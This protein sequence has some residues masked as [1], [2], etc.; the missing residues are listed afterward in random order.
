M[1]MMFAA[2]LVLIMEYVIPIFNTVWGLWYC[3]KMFLNSFYCIC[4]VC[5]RDFSQEL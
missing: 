1:N 4:L 3:M 2:F 5:E